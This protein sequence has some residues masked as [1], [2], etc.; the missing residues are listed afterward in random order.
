MAVV[1]KRVASLSDMFSGEAGAEGLPRPG[2]VENDFIS[3]IIRRVREARVIP[4]VSGSVFY[5]SVFRLEA[6]AEPVP[7]AAAS[8]AEEAAEELPAEEQTIQSE[9]SS[10]WARQIGYPLPDQGNLPRVAQYNRTL[11]EDNERAKVGYLRFL[12]MALL[13]FARVNGAESSLIGELRD[14][15]DEAS[16]TDL[17]QELGYPREDTTRLDPLRVLA[18]LPLPVYITTSYHDYLERLLTLENR[19]PRTQICF[20]SGEA[21]DVDDSHATDRELTPSVAQPVVYHL[22]GLERYP[23][24]IALSEDDY[25]DFLARVVLDT[26]TRD[27]VI[28]LYLRDALSFSSLVLLGYRLSD[29]DFRVLFRGVIL[30]RQSPNRWT[31]LIIQLTPE[32]QYHIAEADKARKYLETYFSPRSF[33]IEWGNAESYLAKFWSE[34]KKR[35]V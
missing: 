21:L 33:K 17:C 24:S 7:P 29:W 18:R 11:S 2:Q 20:W 26:D 9:L 10:T 28:P 6:A 31:S 5:E 19:Q 22:M 13:N 8:P 14:R 4:V 30:P 27:M 12:K 32:E 15:L 25:L 34:W 16:F 1:R 35:Q 3:E 23:S